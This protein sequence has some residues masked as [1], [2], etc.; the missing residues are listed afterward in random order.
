MTVKVPFSLIPPNKLRQQAR[1]FLPLSQKVKKLLPF[2]KIQLRYAQME[3]EAR[4]YLAMCLLATTIFFVFSTVLIG[5]N[6]ALFAESKAA[7]L[8]APLVALFISIFVFL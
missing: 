8:L 1:I 7:I 3:I 6:L 5:I 2:L 4:E